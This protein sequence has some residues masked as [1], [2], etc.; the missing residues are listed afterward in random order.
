[1]LGQQQFILGDLILIQKKQDIISQQ[2]TG[3]N[4]SVIT[5]KMEH[6]IVPEPL[7]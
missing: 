6:P 1:M 7:E 5:L 4:C 2:I 3:V